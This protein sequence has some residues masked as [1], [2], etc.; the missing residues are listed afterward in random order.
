M[1]K[2]PVFALFTLA[3]CFSLVWTGCKKEDTV[4][5]VVTLIGD[6][7]VAVDLGG[8]YTDAG[9]TAIDDVDGDVTSNI[10]VSNPVDTQ[11]SGTYVVIYAVPDAAGNVGSANR[12]VTVTP[13]RNSYL[14]SY[15]TVE[16]CPSPY[17]LS[18]TPT[19]SAGAAANEI[20]LAPYYFNGGS[21]TMIVDGS[22]VTIAANQNPGPIGDNASGSGTLSSDGKVISMTVTMT[23]SVGQPVTCNV[24][25]TKP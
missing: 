18:S 23:P 6:A 7:S 25:W 19:I 10:E 5:P 4:P 3:I 17:G 12:T 21:I 20:V 22:T 15:S 14:G 16:D 2:S 13:N 8:T 24:T 9:A 1:K 11:K